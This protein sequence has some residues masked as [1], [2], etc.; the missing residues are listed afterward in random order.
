MLLMYN[1][2]CKT[3]LS[4]I[5]VYLF[6]RLLVYS[7]TCFYFVIFG[8][9]RHSPNKFGSALACT[10]ISRLLIYDF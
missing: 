8:C 10:K 5:L 2:V 1:T 3:V 7:F 9:A 6:T 4:R